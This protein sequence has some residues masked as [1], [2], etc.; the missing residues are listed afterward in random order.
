VKNAAVVFLALSLLLLLAAA[1]VMA[2]PTNGQKVPAIMT[3][4][5]PPKITM[6]DP[7]EVWKTNG[8]VSH[9]RDTIINYTFLFIIDGAP[10]ITGY[11]ITVRDGNG[12]IPKTGMFSY[13][14][15]YEFWFP[16]VGGGFE[17]RGL[18]H[19]F[20]FV[21]MSSYDLE[22]HVILHGTGSFEGQTL[23]MW[24]TGGPTGPGWTGYLLKP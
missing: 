3:F 6:L 12:I 4:P 11:A 9:R 21:S 8:N 24:R 14:E 7:G 15:Y 13:H 22:I 18:S 1:P 10:P 19:Y 23:N 20:D 17:G 16:T 5:V 2:E